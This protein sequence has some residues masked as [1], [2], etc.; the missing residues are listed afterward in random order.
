LRIEVRAGPSGCP[1]ASA[2]RIAPGQPLGA[3]ETETFLHVEG[4]RSGEIRLLD[5]DLRP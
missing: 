1:F 2:E 4:E 3:E 5:D